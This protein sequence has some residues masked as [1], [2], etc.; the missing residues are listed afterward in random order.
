MNHFTLA[1]LLLGILQ[2]CQ[3]ESETHQTS[4]INA[5]QATDPSLTGIWGLT[6]YFDT[7]LAHREIAAYRTQPPTWFALLLTIEGDSITSHGSI[8]D[9][10]KRIDM[11]GDTVHQYDTYGGP[12]ALVKAGEELH[13]VQQPGAERPDSTIYRYRRREDLRW[14][15]ENLDKVHKTSSHVTQYFNEELLAGT[16]QLNDSEKLVTFYPS[17]DLTGIEGIASFAVDNYF[18]T[19]HPF[20]N[21]D[22]LTFYPANK[23]QPEWYN[24]VFEGQKLTLTEMVREKVVH[25]GKQVEGDNFELGT[26]QLTLTQSLQVA[27]VTAP[28]GLSYRKQPGIDSKKLGTFDLGTKVYVIEKTDIPF[29]IEEEGRTISGHW[30]KVKAGTDRTDTEYW[31]RPLKYTGYVF[32]GYLVD[33]V[34]ADFTK[35]P[36]FERDSVDDKY[37]EG[38][39]LS[40]RVESIDSSTFATYQKAYENPVHFD[41]TKTAQPGKYV[42]IQTAKFQYKLPCVIQWQCYYYAGYS[43]S[44][45]AYY[46]WNTREIAQLQLIDS[47]TGIT[48]ILH[49]SENGSIPFV[50]K[51]G[52]QFVTYAA[53]DYEGTSRVALYQRADSGDSFDYRVYDQFETTK[54]LIQQLVWV[55]E[56]TFAMR[57]DDGHVRDSQEEWGRKNERY[58]K[59]VIQ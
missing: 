9:R 24:W 44:L 3:P 36:R 26:K 18:G 11:Q 14:M 22:I 27:Y 58:L 38:G 46:V 50:S 12:W 57:V 42:V 17:G 51:E 28:N 30:V 34:K 19:S 37:V 35:L 7:I 54:W 23:G 16:Y 55:D 31:F 5:H 25:N 47:L 13:L 2:S 59:V 32:D 45:R 20:N 8:I 48:H 53:S 49:S 40:L 21:L 1:L 41:S 33:S 43:P 6:H 15:T 4:K 10:K 52:N 56:K 29:A 39:K